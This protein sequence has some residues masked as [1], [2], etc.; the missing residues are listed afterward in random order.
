MHN[1]I[2]HWEAK[3]ASEAELVEM[4]MDWR[5]RRLGMHQFPLRLL[6]HPIHGRPT[7]C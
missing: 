3:F 6:G 5:T 7:Y 1:F 2:L 4:S